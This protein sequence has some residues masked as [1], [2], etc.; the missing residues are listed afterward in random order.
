MFAL[1]IVILQF[2]VCWL[3]LPLMR[4]ANEL[5]HAPRSTDTN[6]VPKAGPTVH[7]VPLAEVDGAPGVVP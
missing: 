5:I 6:L 3:K 7:E 2:T 4:L 1:V